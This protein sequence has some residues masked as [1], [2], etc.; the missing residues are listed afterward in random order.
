MSAPYSIDMDQSTNG[1]T[2]NISSKGH[3]SDLTNDIHPY[4]ADTDIHGVPISTP[5]LR[6]FS[7]LSPH[8]ETML[9]N[10]L[11]KLEGVSTALPG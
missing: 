6:R 9:N 5:Q 3:Y 11:E 4:D 8:D 7:S 2:P 10:L 1:S